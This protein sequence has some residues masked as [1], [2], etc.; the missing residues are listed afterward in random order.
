MWSKLVINL[1]FLF[2]SG[3]SVFLYRFSVRS[4]NNFEF[5]MYFYCFASTAQANYY[6]YGRSTSNFSPESGSRARHGLSSPSLPHSKTFSSKVWRHFCQPTARVWSIT[7]G[8]AD[9]QCSTFA[10]AH[11]IFGRCQHFTCWS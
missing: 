10:S 8:I 11:L 3:H 7:S 1:I 6:Y 9:L 5:A 4:D 2:H